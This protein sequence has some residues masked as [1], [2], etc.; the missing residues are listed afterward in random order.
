MVLAEGS[1]LSLFDQIRVGGLL[2]AFAVIAGTW[3]AVRLVSG[4]AARLGQR[5]GDR[6]LF[7]NQL[8]T[9]ARFVIWSGG[10]VIGVLA[11]NL[12]REF[13]LTLLGAA[14]VTIGFGLK[15]LTSSILAGLTIIIDQPF[16]VGDR[17]TF[18][19]YY[20][21]ITAI[22]LRSVR[23]VTLDDNVVTIPNN[24]FLTDVTASGNAGA[25]DMMVQV[26]FHVGPDQDLM[27]AKKLVERCVVENPYVYTKKP[28][29]VNVAQVFKGEYF[30]YQLRAK[31]YVLDVKHEK[32]YETELTERV[33]LA[34]AKEGIRPPSLIV[35]QEPTPLGGAQAKARSTLPPS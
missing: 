35:R 25:L 23:L 11:L 29:T 2:S 15:D 31:A 20:G 17:V 16:Q 19:G 4:F 30:A 33:H 22:G 12:S 32:T 3:F 7:F 1:P 34:F 10:I 24:K 13:V 18:G 14:A 8:G 21:E 28:W 5:F 9:A 6:R 26:D 27:L